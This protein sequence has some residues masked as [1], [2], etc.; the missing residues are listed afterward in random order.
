MYPL[1]R[2]IKWLNPNHY[3][4]SIIRTCITHCTPHV[5]WIV[6]MDNFTAKAK[7]YSKPFYTSPT[8]YNLCLLFSFNSSEHYDHSH[9]HTH[10]H[11]QR[12]TMYSPYNIHN[13]SSPTH[14]LHTLS[15][16]VDIIYHHSCIHTRGICRF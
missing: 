6:K 12:H 4:Y 3:C 2:Q 14:N 15:D 5:M 11:T 7:R 1:D 13:T 16:S 8:S 10:T 9:T